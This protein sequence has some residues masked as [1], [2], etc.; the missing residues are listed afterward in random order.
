MKR[1]IAP[2]LAILLLSTAVAFAVTLDG[3]KLK[4]SF[5]DLLQISNANSGIDATL[6]TL[7][8]GEGT[9]STLQLS[10]TA[11]NV[12]SGLQLNGTAAQ[13]GTTLKHEVGGIEADI[14][15]IADGGLLVGDGAGSM[16]IRAG[17]LTAGAAGF[18]T[19]EAGGIEF[20][21]S[22]V[23]DS[24]F[25]VGTGAGTMALESGATARTSLGVAIGSDVQAWDTQLDD[26]AV[27]AVTGGNI[28]IGDGSN[29]VAEPLTGTPREYTKTQNFDATTLTDEANISWDA[30][31]NQV[32]SVT[33]TDN[34]TLDN[35]TNT[36]DGATYILIIRQDAGGTN[37]L[38][39]GDAYLFPGGTAP[40]LSTGG[41]SVDIISFVASAISDGTQMFGVSQLNFQ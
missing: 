31:A 4:E 39:Y 23:A 9:S 32:A 11:V 19:H 41:L 36:V 10:T 34:R 29:W 40:T 8:D 5:K 37:T 21:A 30:S 25:I 1:Y 15:G 2:T 22:A 16:A 18:L 24:D 28:I 20:D 12:T 13:S 26:I 27:L 33:L 6:R 14:S 17:A 3:Q 35:A 38:S 7:E